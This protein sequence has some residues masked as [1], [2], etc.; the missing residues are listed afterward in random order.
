MKKLLIVLY[1]EE[2]TW[3]LEGIQFSNDWS[4]NKFI[5]LLCQ[6]RYYVAPDPDI[7][8]EKYH[9]WFVPRLNH[10]PL[11]VFHPQIVISYQWDYQQD[12]LNLY[13]QLTQLGY[14]VWLDIFQM[15]GGDSLLEKSNTAIHQSLCLLACI[16]PKYIKSINCQH[17]LSLAKDLNKPIIPLLL[18]ETNSW[19]LN[20]L[21]LTE[22][23]DFRTS[24]NENDRWTG[25][26]F[27]MLLAQLEKIIPNVHTEKP[28]HLL[29]MQR[30]ISATRNN[31]EQKPKRISSAPIIPQSR[32]CSLM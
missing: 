6:I 29:E 12:I 28:R 8:S 4:E 10:I 9:H 13:K 21:Q 2:Q 5:E 20:D 18:E 15:G 24:K 25:K 16:T 7:I 23:I 17:D 32:A 22:Y 30:S 3:P 14:R 11:V 27:E 26:Q 31:Q 1:T 19:P